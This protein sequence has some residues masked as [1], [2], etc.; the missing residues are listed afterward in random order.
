M[1]GFE[2]PTG[3]LPRTVDADELESLPHLIVMDED[4]LVQQVQDGVGHD[5]GKQVKPD[6]LEHAAMPDEHHLQEALPGLLSV[7]VPVR[8][9]A[10]PGLGHLDDFSSSV[11]QLLK[12]Y[13]LN[14]CFHKYRIR[15]FCCCHVRF[16]IG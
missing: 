12:M 16:K 3:A 10:L 4:V 14:E 15:R 5:E 8:K 7:F 2:L 11:F 9:D 6:E 1:E 13:F